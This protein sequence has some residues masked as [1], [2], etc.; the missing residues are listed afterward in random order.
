[1]AA[2][3]EAGAILLTRPDY[4]GRLPDIGGIVRAAHARGMKVLVDEAHGAHLSFL[5]SSA[6][7]AVKC[8]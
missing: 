2:H 1:M 6:A 5:G 4:Y 7:T 8:A 3:P